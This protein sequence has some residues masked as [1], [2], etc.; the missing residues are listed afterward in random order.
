MGAEA[1]RAPGDRIVTQVFILQH[2]SAVQL[3]PV[4]RPLVTANNFIAAYP[5]N[6]AII[7]TPQAAQDKLRQ[8]DKA[9]ADYMRIGKLEPQG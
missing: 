2:E 9:W 5:N 3:V 8:D 4:L 1:T 6:N 7:I